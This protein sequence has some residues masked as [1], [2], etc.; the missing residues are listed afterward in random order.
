MID[1]ISIIFYLNTLSFGQVLP[2]HK[3]SLHVYLYTNNVLEQWKAMILPTK[4][5]V[6]MCKQCI[7]IIIT[8][9]VYITLKVWL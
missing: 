2:G 1:I 9:I 5:I 8:R 7:N 3:L 6:A 4:D